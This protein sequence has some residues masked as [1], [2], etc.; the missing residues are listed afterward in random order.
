M[1]KTHT[2]YYKTTPYNIL[3]IILKLLSPP[4]PLPG[5]QLRIHLQKND[6]GHIYKEK[7]SKYFYL[8]LPEIIKKANS[9]KT[10]P[11]TEHWFALY[12][13]SRTE[14]R[15]YD[16]LT[17]L[18]IHTYLPLR[19]ELKQWSDRKKWVETPVINSYI[20]VRLPE[21]EY[22]SVFE[23]PGVVAYVC[24]KGKAVIIPDHEME[25]MRKTVENKMSFSVESGGLKKGQMVTVTSGPLKGVTG[26]VTQLRGQKKLYLSITNIGFTL[27]VNLDE[28][29]V[30]EEKSE[31]A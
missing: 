24:Y 26:R 14:K 11:K 5:D 22:R 29:T 1:N 15:V 9:L 28:D 21:N 3:L 19:K 10:D 2:K 7:K 30:M 4:C 8:W 25:A 16:S 18:G 20:F 17:R 23:A 12:T 31:T 27:V 6:A 13:K